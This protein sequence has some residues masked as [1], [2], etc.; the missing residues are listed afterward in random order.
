MVEKIDSA[1]DLF[2]R[3]L[4]DLYRAEEQLILALTKMA[5][6]AEAPELRAGLARHLEQTHHHLRRIEQAFSEIHR[7]PAG[8]N[9]PGMGDLI[10]VA[11]D[12]LMTMN[13]GPA[14]DRKLIEVARRIE[15]HEI[16]AY[17][18]IIA[19]AYELGFEV[20]AS[21]LEWNL[22]EEELCEYHLQ[23]VA[24]GLQPAVA[25]N[26]RQPRNRKGNSRPAAGGLL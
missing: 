5:V 8:G 14:L 10:A 20:V 11:E 15:A 13:I 17:R 4:Q 19:T 23:R 21:L 3:D 7:L 9:D 2:I 25:P 12:V 26:S 22:Q 18:A 24:E 1:E 6:G 16:T